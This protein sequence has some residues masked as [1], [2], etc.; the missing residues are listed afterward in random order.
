MPR[1][2]NET[3]E[4]LR[5][6]DPSKKNVIQTGW[7]GEP[8]YRKPEP[9]P[10]ELSDE[11]IIEKKT[12]QKVLKMLVPQFPLLKLDKQ[13]LAEL[14][15]FLGEVKPIIQEEVIRRYQDFSP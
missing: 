10:E 13:S 8:P 5:K 2:S 4:A 6:I 9:P 14:Y 3:R 12:V 7:V 11:Q 1:Q 15:R